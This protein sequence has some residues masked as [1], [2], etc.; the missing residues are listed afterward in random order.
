M[1]HRQTRRSRGRCES[2]RDRK[3]RFQFR[4]QVR[5]DRDHTLCF[6]CFRR[7]RERQRA[8]G[9]VA[10]YPLPL[11]AP[12]S[13]PLEAHDARIHVSARQVEHRQ[14]MLTHMQAQQKGARQPAV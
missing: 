7:E 6:E 12:L 5:A 13:S 2:C 11:E 1:A 9:L 10:Q 4:G 14:R 8:R 3:A